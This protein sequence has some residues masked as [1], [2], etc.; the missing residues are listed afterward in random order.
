MYI[1][2]CVMYEKGASAFAIL[3]IKDSD[4][5]VYVL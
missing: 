4:S 2:E 5:V 1:I 3:R